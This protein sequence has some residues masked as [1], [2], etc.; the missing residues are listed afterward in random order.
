MPKAPN[1]GLGKTTPLPSA[2]GRKPIPTQ[3]PKDKPSNPKE[4]KPTAPVDYLPPVP[5][6]GTSLADLKKRMAALVKQTQKAEAPAGG[7]LSTKGGRLTH[8]DVELPGNAIQA[9]IAYY[10]KD[11]EY[12]PE[13][14]VAG[15]PASP[16]CHAV[17]RP[18]EIITPWRKLREGEEVQEGMHYS[19]ELGLVSDAQQPQVVAGLG[20]DSCTMLDWNT[21]DGGRGRGKACRESRRLT[22]LAADQCTTPDDVLRAPTMTMIPPPTS[23]DN[24]KR[25]A[26][27]ITTVLDTP[28]FGAIVEISVKS[29]EKY[30][31]MV[32]YKVMEQITDPGILQALL[33]RHEQ[34]GAKPIVV[35]KLNDDD[36][37]KNARG[38]KF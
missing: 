33:V 7:F 13:K 30:L 4:K 36:A 38:S 35:P 29:H 3:T 5:Q 2:S 10:H 23:L 8:G 12:Y 17:V 25:V 19:Q 27:E 34:I 11:N 20:C 32:H 6:Q 26:N 28:I 16:L 31:F 24:F 9:I 1:P 15:K 18:H 37:V 21:A 22:I 14:Y